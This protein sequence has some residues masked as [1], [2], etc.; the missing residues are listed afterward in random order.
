MKVLT[1]LMVLLLVSLGMQASV[2][3]YDVVV[4]EDRTSGTILL[5][6]TIPLANKTEMSI[7]DRAGNSLFSQSLAGNRFL[8]KRFKRASLPN[9]DYYLV[10]SD[11]LGRTTIPL[12]V[13][14][15]AIIG[16]IQGA[17]QVIYPTLD[18]QNKRMLVLY[19]DNQT[20]KRVNVRLT[21]E[22]GDQV[23]SDQLVGESI[24]RSYQLKNLDAGNYFVTVSSRDVKSYTAAIAL[25]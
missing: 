23:F 25:Q 19:Y 9:G 24:K 18:L 16:D 6:T 3:P 11:S 14:R 2:D 21:N 22:N 8:N 10:F 20:G 1:T 13:S 4:S 7:L 17:I 15:E 5:R 12:S